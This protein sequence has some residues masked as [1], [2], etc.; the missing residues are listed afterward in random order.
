MRLPIALAVLL[1]AGS[2]RA[3]VINVSPADGNT[4]YT[5]IEGANPG[6][7]VVIAPGTYAFRVYLEQQAPASAPIYIHAQDPSN[8]PVWDFGNT[9]IESEPG[10]Y[11]AP[12]KNRGCWQLSG[13]SNIHIDGIVFTHCRDSVHPGAGAGIRYYNGTTG[14]LITNCVFHDNDNGLTGGTIGDDG[15]TQSEATIEFSEF[16]SNGNLNASAATHNI[17]NYGGYFTLR[18]SYLHDPTQAQNLHCRA[19]NSTIEYNWFDRAAA[20]VGDLMT[21]DDYANN[22]V[23]SL[24]QT[25]L[26]RGNVIIQAG[27]QANT[28]QI[29]ALYNDEASGSPV[30]F[31]VTAEYN[32]VIGA[33]G[34]AAFIHLSN[35][36]QTVMSAE[37]DNNIISG[38]SQPT[39]VEDT[40]F[41]TVTGTNNWIQTGADAT[42]LSNSIVGSA[43]GYTDAAN[44]DFTLA[45]GSA[46]IGA[47]DLSV[48]NLPTAEYF[49][50]E[51]VTREYRA[52]ASAN[53]LGA[54]EHDTQGSGI[55]PYGDGGFVSTSGTT[56]STSTSSASS[57]GATTATSTTTGTSSTSTTTASSTTGTSSSSTTT[58]ASTTG[59]STGTETSTTSSGSGSTSASS[60]GGTSSGAS[61]SSTTGGG[62][63]GGST[64]GGTPGK[65]NGGCGCS[66]GS[67]GSPLWLAFG[68][69]VLIS[70]RRARSFRRSAA[71]AERCSPR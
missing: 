68:L 59:A 34:H 67:D 12:D 45:T 65:V 4:A 35:A 50:N 28:G 15:V 37:L 27:T 17:Y 70:T 63:A 7:E 60:T 21:N 42:G 9:D 41:A 14:L 13:A 52:R 2:A 29:W 33:G 49:Q 36:D 55:G 1:A 30:S 18:F 38:T 43:P 26:V 57:T 23:G 16:Y 58:A 3:A 71:D 69:A 10:S 5:K 48:G 56:T 25:M 53:D 22:P 24:Q 40:G 64:T 47:A 51:S 6:D 66:A 8:P 54:F 11:T 31:S 39:L 19:I 32:T 46:A 61:S 20:Y 62:S 44:L